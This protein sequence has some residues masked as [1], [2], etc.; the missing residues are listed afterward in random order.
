MVIG[1]L[2]KTRFTGVYKRESDGRYVVRATARACGKFVQ[3]TEVQEEGCTLESARR[4]AEVLRQRVVEDAEEIR[5]TGNDITVPG[6]KGTSTPAKVETLKEYGLRW[7]RGK[8]AR[9]KKGPA[10]TYYDALS[11]K[12][13]PRLGDYRVTDISRSVVEDWVAWVERQ[14]KA[15]GDPYAQDTLTGWFRVLT[16]LLRDMAADYDL[17]D[18]VRRIRGPHSNRKNT[19]EQRTLSPEELHRFLEAARKVVPQHYV[20]M[21]TLATTGMRV[22][23]VFALQWDCIDFKREEFI[24]RRG[25]SGG[26]PV[27]ST[28]TDDPRT[29]PMHPVLAEALREHRKQ[30]LASQHPGVDT[31]LVFPSN[32][33]TM[34]FASGIYKAYGLAREAAKIDQKVNN[35]V[36]RRTMNTMLRRSGVDRIVLRNVMGHSSEEMTERYSWVDGSEKRQAILKVFPTGGKTAT[37]G[38]RE[39]GE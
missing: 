23:E 19:Q 14:R 36:L 33:G 30:L 1:K 38:D 6:K 24:V 27:E 21:L 31:N 25:R 8:A 2:S 16:R 22:S 5:A 32:K 26:D 15:D 35:Q 18:P 39:D 11:L 37:G 29:V 4:R 12:I 20:A 7:W 10:D 3:R 28:K 9:I 34:R 17:P 13:W